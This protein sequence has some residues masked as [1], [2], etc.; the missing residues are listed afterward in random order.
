MINCCK[1]STWTTRIQWKDEVF[2]SWFK[3]CCWNHCIHSISCSRTPRTTP[4]MLRVLFSVGN[5]RGI[6]FIWVVPPKKTEG[7]ERLSII[8]GIISWEIVDW[9]RLIDEKN[10]LRWGFLVHVPW[11]SPCTRWEFLVYMANPAGF[12]S[13]VWGRLKKWYFHQPKAFIW[14]FNQLLP[15]KWRLYP[16]G[17]DP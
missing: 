2:V 16:N 11:Q 8:S 10:Q 14:N 7:T 5:V 15:S 1:D 13:D 4:R 12:Q 6:H 17:G 9:A 3:C